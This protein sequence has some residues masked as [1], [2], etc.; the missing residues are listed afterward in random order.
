M[1]STEAQQLP[2][3]IRPPKVWPLIVVSLVSLVLSFAAAVQ[4]R[5]NALQDGRVAGRVDANTELICDAARARQTTKPATPLE[6]RMR[7]ITADTD[8]VCV[9][10]GADQ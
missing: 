1:T 8:A 3:E 2:E 9:A 5:S 6:K 7:D 4:S 10:E